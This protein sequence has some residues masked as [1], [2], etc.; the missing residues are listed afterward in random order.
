LPV[1]ISSALETSVGI[2]MG[3]Y[4]AASIETLAF[5]CGLATV[6]LLGADV[7][8]D[9]LVPVAGLIDVRRVV[10]DSALLDTHAVD[11]HR[12]EWWRARIERSHRLLE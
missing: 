11:A 5:D 1:V 8:T 2:S 4:L 10:P 9:S 6:N 12:L 3:A 7:T